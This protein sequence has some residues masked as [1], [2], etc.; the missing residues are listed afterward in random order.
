M[1]RLG[2]LPF[3]RGGMEQVAPPHLHRDAEYSY[4]IALPSGEGCSG[5]HFRATDSSLRMW[6]HSGCEAVIPAAVIVEL[7]CAG[8]T[9]ASIK[10]DE[11]IQ[12]E[13]LPGQARQ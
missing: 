11:S 4:A 8:L 1:A 7:S 12:C 2:D 13:G 3:S 6:R 5:R 9:R 10:K